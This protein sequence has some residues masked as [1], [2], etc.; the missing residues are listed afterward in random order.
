MRCKTTI[1]RG[2]LLDLLDTNDTNEYH[3]H[4]MA[5]WAIAIP[6]DVIKSRLQTAPEGTYTGMLDVY[7]TLMR[8]EGAGALFRGIGPAMTRAFPANAA[9]FFGVDIANRFL[10]KLGI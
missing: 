3:V 7:R 10:E 8:Q 2:A 5:N 1:I 9:C 4:G 6:P